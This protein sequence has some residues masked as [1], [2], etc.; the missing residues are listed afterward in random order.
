MGWASGRMFYLPQGK[1]GSEQGRTISTFN[2]PHTI[3]RS[4]TVAH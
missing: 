2:E 1:S 4:K 3:T